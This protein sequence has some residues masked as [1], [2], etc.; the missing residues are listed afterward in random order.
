MRRIVYEENPENYILKKS[1]MRKIRR[2]AY[3]E[4]PENY[5]KEEFRL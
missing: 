5:I 1:L 4:N 2:I 3:E